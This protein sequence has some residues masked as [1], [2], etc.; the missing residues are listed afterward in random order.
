[1]I[2]APTFASLEAFD[3][4]VTRVLP[5]LDRDTSLVDDF[6]ETQV[7]PRAFDPTDFERTRELPRVTSSPA[8]RP[9]RRHTTHKLTALVVRADRA[10]RLLRLRH[11]S[12]SPTFGAPTIFYFVAITAF[13]MAL[14]FLC[15][16]HAHVR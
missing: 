4:E 15:G 13:A 14:G 10:L 9:I 12:W 5:R 11:F 8:A 16:S 2:S 1:M 7:R 3:G 6:E